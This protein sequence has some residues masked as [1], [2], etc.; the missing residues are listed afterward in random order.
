MTAICRMTRNFSRRLTALNS[1]KLS[2][3]SPACSRNAFPLATWPS[4]VCSDRAS[5][6]NTSGGYVPICFSARSTAPS[7]GQS[8]C[9]AAGNDRHDE[10][11]H[12]RLIGTAVYAP[13]VRG[14]RP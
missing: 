14:L 11:V 2:A 10:G 13:V 1:S 7:S 9:W 5:P 12:P 6:A 4:A 3:Q 8:G